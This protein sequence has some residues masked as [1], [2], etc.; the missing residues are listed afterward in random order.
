MEYYLI[1][2]KGF[3][4]NEVLSPS[5][6]LKEISLKYKSETDFVRLN[7]DRRNLVLGNL[8]E[9]EI[10]L[11]DF[12]SWDEMFH[13]KEITHEEWTTKYK[14]ID[15]YDVHMWKDG[16]WHS[17]LDIVKREIKFDNLDGTTDKC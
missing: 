2:Y 1:I 12:D 7:R 3:D 8:T 17:I 10:E 14:D 9:D 5:N 6:N 11:L 15:F 13:R 4:G 16:E